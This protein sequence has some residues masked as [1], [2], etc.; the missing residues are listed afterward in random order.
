MKSAGSSKKLV[1]HG[2]IMLQGSNSA[3]G[4]LPSV[5]G[6]TAP[7][8]RWRSEDTD[9]GLRVFCD[10]P[11]TTSDHWC[12]TDRVSYHVDCCYGEPCPIC[13]DVLQACPKDN[14]C[15]TPKDVLVPLI[16]QAKSH[17]HTTKQSV[18]QRDTHVS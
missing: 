16:E 7:Q 18:L 9:L 3:T 6:D 13:G 5:V 12:A 1:V 8:P 15:Q 11:T 10:R 4:G 17:S 2:Q 14:G